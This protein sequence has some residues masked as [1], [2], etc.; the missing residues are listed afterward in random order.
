MK[1]CIDPGH[2]GY[3]PGAVNHNVG[4]TEKA[5]SL[6]IA[7]LLGGELA[8]RGY[9]VFFTRELDTF[10]PL[11]FRT[12][13]ANNEK[14]DLFISIHLNAAADPAAQGIETWYYEGSRESERL[15][16]IVQRE[17][18][19]QF[20]AKNRGIKSTRGFYVLKHTAMPAILVETGFITNDHDIAYL[21]NKVLCYYIRVVIYT[22]LN[23]LDRPVKNGLFFTLKIRHKSHFF[24]ILVKNLLQFSIL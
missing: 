17:L 23:S 5:L 7:A 2:G 8:S 9:D 22:S 21:V 16:A 3:D 15:A 18:K 24:K 12:K 13:I 4:V 10:I 6:K 20:L 1:I 19:D 11:G 14:A